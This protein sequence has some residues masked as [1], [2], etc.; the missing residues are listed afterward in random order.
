MDLLDNPV[1]AALSGPHAGHAE[2]YGR[3]ARYDP[4]ISPFAAV[5]DPA[6]PGA[7]DDLRSLVGVGNRALLAGP[8]L[9]TPPG[10]T[11][12]RSLP[13]VQ[14][15]GTGAGAGGGD[16]EVVV[17]TGADL[18][19]MLDLVARTRPGPFRKRTV[20]L[21]TYAGIRRDGALV[22]MAGER[23]RLPG[24]TEISAVCTDPAYRGAGLAAR[25]VAH[26]GAGIRQRGE[27]PFLHAAADNAGAIRLY[28][29]LGFTV[30]T[31]V[32]FMSATAA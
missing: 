23:M 15:V 5:D 12:D 27:V 21:G 6:D 28:R 31:D 19:E 9:A 16:P 32:R 1:W 29:R 17:L 25:L 3:S 4:E 18:P 11:S 22:A 7:W 20:E 24:H 30:R 2:R 13:G 14:L 26:I 8:G 10:W